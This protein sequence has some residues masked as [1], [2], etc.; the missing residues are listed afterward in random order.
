M[1]VERDNNAEREERIEKILRDVAR[2]QERVEK[3]A[4]EG[5]R[6]AAEIAHDRDAA[7][8]DT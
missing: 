8:R 2:V 5:R 4:A 7:L 6:R 3:L 1:S